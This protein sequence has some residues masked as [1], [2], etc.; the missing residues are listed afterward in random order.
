M[1]L[2]AVLFPVAVYLGIL[3]LVNRRSHGLL[4]SGPW[5]FAGILFAASGLLLFGGPALLSSLMRTDTWRAWWLQARFH[6]A[7]D[8][9]ALGR[10]VAYAIYFLVVIL[11]TVLVLRRRR[12]FTALYN[13]H[14]SLVEAVLGEVF[15]RWRLPFVQ[16]GNVLLIDPE[17]ASAA[18]Q[19]S[20]LVERMT[21]LEVE[22][23]LGMCHVTLCW[24]P[25]DSLLRREVESQL[26]LALAQKPA[27][28]GAVGDWFLLAGSTLF[29]LIVIGT[30]ILLLLRFVRM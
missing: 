5:D 29:F 22:A 25:P 26:R 11:T 2:L 16:T 15:E 14:P 4:V 1:L 6:N 12:R 13:V 27:P 19:A 30:G 23:S 9:I 21:T 3:G 17:Q 10:I 8:P 7:D 20:V 24:Q 28:R 18:R